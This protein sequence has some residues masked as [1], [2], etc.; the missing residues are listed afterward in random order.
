MVSGDI[1]H[2]PWLAAPPV[3]SV[4]LHGRMNPRETATVV[5]HPMSRSATVPDSPIAREAA[6]GHKTA[7]GLAWMI[8]QTVLTKLVTT[9]GTLLLGKLL[10]DDDFGLAALA[11]AFSVIP[12]LVQQGGLREILIQ[13]HHQFRRWANA[14]FWM[15]IAQGL[16]AGVLMAALAPIGSLMYGNSTFVGLLLVLAAVF[17]LDAL[18]IAPQ[19]NLQNQMRFRSLAALE[20]GKAVGQI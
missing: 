8:S 1:P 2:G 17:P 16:V 3:R 6:L 20:L 4:R 11:Y 10:L 7:R 13:R 18:L 19:A 5:E 9:L 15:S 12:S 14:A